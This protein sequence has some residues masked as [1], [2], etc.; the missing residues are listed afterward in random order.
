MVLY[1]RRCV[2]TTLEGRSISCVY[3]VILERPVGNTAD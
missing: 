2:S 1:S 3:A